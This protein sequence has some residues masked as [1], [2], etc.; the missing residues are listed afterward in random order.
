MENNAKA[1]V[2]KGVKILVFLIIIIALL[3]NIQGRFVPYNARYSDGSFT[4][5]EIPENSIDVLIAGTSTTLTGLAPLKLYEDTQIMSY[6][7]CN[8]YQAPQITYLNVKE[9]L[10]YQKPKVVICSVKSLFW[11]YHSVDEMQP[12][13]IY[14]GMDYK[15]LSFD[16]VKIGMALAKG[17]NNYS[18]SELVFPLV[19]YHSKWETSFENI[20]SEPKE[21]WDSYRGHDPKYICMEIVDKSEEN[22]NDTKAVMLSDKS[23]DWYKKISNLCKKNNIKLLLVEMPNVNWTMGKH[24]AVVKVA[25]NL[26]AN[27]LDYNYNDILQKCE[28]KFNEDFLDGGHLNTRGS[29]KAT[30]YLG[31]YIQSKY[32]LDANRTSGEAKSQ[33]EK[34]LQVFNKEIEVTEYEYREDK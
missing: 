29:I 33:F 8:S 19:R 5:Y 22:M 27:F 1:L 7:R 16:K 4:F 32:K 11:T 13:G 24:N 23:I 26:D 30:D 14:I 9:A 28:I 31:K 17:S 25:D 3:L 6:S 18:L 12:A 2:L 20:V 10:H 34:D 15:K 21:K